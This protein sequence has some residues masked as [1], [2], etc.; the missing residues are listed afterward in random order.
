MERI[1][2]SALSPRFLLGQPNRSALILSGFAAAIC[3]V[4][5]VLAQAPDQTD[6]PSASALTTPTTEVPIEVDAWSDGI[7]TAAMSGDQAMLDEYLANV[8]ATAQPGRAQ[9]LRDAIDSYR[10]HLNAASVDRTEDRD[11]AL[12]R[13]KEHLAAD[14]IVK[15]LTAAVEVQTLADDWDEMLQIEQMQM[16][17]SRSQSDWK[18]ALEAGDLLLAQDLLYRLR[19]LNEDIGEPEAYKRYD[20]ALDDVNRRISLLAQYAQR[21]LHE[22]RREEM[23]RYAP[24]EEFPEFNDAFAGEWKERLRNI[25]DRMLKRALVMASRDHIAAGGWKPLLEGGLES[26]RIF[27]TT[28]ALKENFEGL[29]KLEMVD[30]FDAFLEIHEKRIQDMPDDALNGETCR[31][32]IDEVLLAN[33]RTVQIEPAVIIREFGDGAM[34]RL[35]KDF[36]DEYSQVIWPEELR[37]FQQQVDGDFVGVGILIRH[38]DRRRIMIVNPLEGSPAARSGIKAGDIILGVEDKDTVGWSLN[39]A[40]DEITGP[41]DQEVTLKIEREGL[42]EPFDVAVMRDQ[43]KMRSVN[44]WW[45]NELS[46]EGEPDWDWFIDETDGIGYIRLTSFNE[47]SFQDF[48]T[49]LQEMHEERPLN[50]LI[51]DLRFNPGGLLRSAVEFTNLFVESG[52]IV[53]GEDRNRN[54]VW[55]LSAEPGRAACMG[56]PTVVLVNRGSASA[57]EI[58]AGALKAHS[59]AVVLGERSFGKGSVQTVHDLSSPF[60]Q[61]AVKLTTQYYVLP[62]LP[63]ESTGRLVHKKPGSDDWGV[64]PHISVEM[65]PEQIMDATELRRKADFIEEWVAEDDREARPEVG[66]LVLEGKD[67][68]LEMGLLL[69][70]ARV[71]KD[72]RNP[73]LLV[74]SSEVSN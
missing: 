37:R 66:P 6:D 44:G 59:A 3:C 61:A 65:A 21:T 68:Q 56:L 62:P 60:S 51:L 52:T 46:A 5:Q 41:A 12:E 8:P 70:K 34:Y 18:E 74:E 43:I 25:N 15:A 47:D 53:S 23:A 31:R 7:W 48:L 38:D 69:L 1:N 16:L 4:P 2:S 17:L 45:K 57:S 50:G 28:A 24:E 10:S 13:L 42:D 40:V 39:Q 32:L 67:P 29:G 63:G 9:A 71:L 73:D 20:N 36:Q 26:L 49:A 35:E 30:R 33:N 72:R 11:A 27:V 58:V 64:N 22:L 55:E 19:T 14:E 54:K